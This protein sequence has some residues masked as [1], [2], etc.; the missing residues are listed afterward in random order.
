MIFFITLPQYFPN[1]LQNA[2]LSSQQPTAMWHR[3]CCIS[4]EVRVGN[5]EELPEVL[6]PETEILNA[7]MEIRQWEAMS[8]MDVIYSCTITIKIIN[9]S[10]RFAA[11]PWYHNCSTHLNNCSS[12]SQPVLARGLIPNA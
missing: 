1:N 5:K 2:R 10:K 12:L 11:S 3:F 8:P 9:I 7:Q 6:P 4:R